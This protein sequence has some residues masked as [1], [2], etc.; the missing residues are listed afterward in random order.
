LAEYGD[1][2]EQVSVRINSD[3]LAFVLALS[4]APSLTAAARTLGKSPAAV[5]M[6]LQGL[7]A[8]LG[9][10]LMDRTN[11]RLMLTDEGELVCE[12]ARLVLADLTALDA[13]LST[14][15]GLQSGSLRVVA[16]HG[17]GR[18]FV[19]HAIS[20]F[21][22]SY[23]QVRVDLVLTDRLGRL[24]DAP[25]DV[26][27]HI[28]KLPDTRLLRRVLAPNERWLV[29]APRYLKASG[30]PTTPADLRSHA[31]LA[32][33]ENEEDVTFWRF[34]QHGRAMPVRIDPVLS[35]ND[36]EAILHWALQG[37][38]L[39]VRSEWQVAADVASGRLVRVLPSYK[40]ASAPVVALT[41][42]RAT[43]PKRISAFLA[44]LKAELR[45]VPWR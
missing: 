21:R 28:G 45:P 9:A 32:L 11:R 24:P 26:A 7:E 19:V 39:I 15:R 6:R 20:A 33:R 2:S 31:C 4:E 13:A 14:R 37:F 43:T 40:L 8:R 12:H 35:S 23:P 27:I 34:E 17:F 16:S 38:G 29:A 5:T 30:V 41:S 36:S 22:Q 1:W 25:W 42:P 10:R 3:D 44:V 18:A